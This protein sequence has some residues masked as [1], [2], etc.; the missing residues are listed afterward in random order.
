MQFLCSCGYS[1]Y[2]FHSNTNILD[3]NLELDRQL[4]LIHVNRSVANLFLYLI[5]ANS[6]LLSG[7]ITPSSHKF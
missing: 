2:D 4:F 6:S 1:E 5:I 3:Y 7:M